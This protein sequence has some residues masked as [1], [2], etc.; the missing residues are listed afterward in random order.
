MTLTAFI[1]NGFSIYKRS[2]FRGLVVLQ[3]ATTRVSSSLVTSE[4]T[5]YTGKF[6]CLEPQALLIPSDFRNLLVL[7]YLLFSL[8]VR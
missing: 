1:P 3:Q 6:S 7:V 2:G 4:Y 5:A 8:R